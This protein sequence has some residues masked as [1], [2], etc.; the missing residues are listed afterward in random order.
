VLQDKKTLKEYGIGKI[1]FSDSKAKME[2][3]EPVYFHCSLSDYKSSKPSEA[4]VKKIH[5]TIPF[6]GNSFSDM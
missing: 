6:F 5:V 2:P 1:T 3:A 4:N